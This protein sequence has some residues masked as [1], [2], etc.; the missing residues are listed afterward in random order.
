M[1]TKQK[2]FSGLKLL[3]TVYLFNVFGFFIKAAGYNK[4]YSLSEAFSPIKMA[5]D[6]ISGNK[7]TLLFTISGVL[8]FTLFKYWRTTKVDYWRGGKGHFPPS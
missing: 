7:I 8:F 5:D 4:K 1:E 2:I 3:I 6:I